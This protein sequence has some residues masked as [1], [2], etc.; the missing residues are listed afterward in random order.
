MTNVRSRITTNRKVDNQHNV[1]HGASR[2]V[3]KT[4]TK[5]RRAFRLLECLKTNSVVARLGTTKFVNIESR[6]NPFALSHV[7]LI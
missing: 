4:P 7:Q 1:E 2:N 5:R 6:I 3:G